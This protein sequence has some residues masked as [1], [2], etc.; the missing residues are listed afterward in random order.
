MRKLPSAVGVVIIAPWLLAPL[1][2]HASVFGSLANFDVVNDTGKDAWGFEIEI[3]DP[4]FDHTKVVSIF[5]KNRSFGSVAGGDP[6]AVVRFGSVDVIDHAGGVTIRYGGNLASGIKTP[7]GVYVTPGESCWPGANPGWQ[8]NPCDHFGI[9]TVGT[10]AAT[11]YSW[12]VESSAGSGVLVNQQTGVP[13]VSFTP[14]P[15]LVQGQPQVV[16]V[17]IRAVA[18]PL[19]PV[20]AEPPEFVALWGEPYWVKMTKTSMKIGENIDLADLLRG[21]NGNP[22]F[23]T[24]TEIEWSVLQN[25][26]ANH[27]GD[28]VNEVKEKNDELGGND[29]AIIRRYEFYKYTGLVNEDGSGEVVCNDLCETDPYG[30]VSGDPNGHFGTIYVGTYVGQQLA[31]FNAVQALAPVPEPETYAMMLAGLGMVFGMRRRRKPRG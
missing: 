22:D 27:I 12:L 15:P 6:L 28:G 25:A 7:S 5:G 20:V 29:K 14:Q 24:E 9:T 21:A 3:E 11:K 8:G 17:Q 13:S 26:P 10:P 18:P 2:A 16:Q 31:G 30:L 23:E 19:P 4:L 1:V